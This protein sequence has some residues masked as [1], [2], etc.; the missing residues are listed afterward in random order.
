M[1]DAPKPLVIGP[2]SI[3]PT[4]GL[5]TEANAGHP[6][7]APGYAI[8]EHIVVGVSVLVIT[9]T[10]PG[11]QITSGYLSQE[12]PVRSWVHAQLRTTVY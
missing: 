1:Q 7:G 3:E 9:G 10:E 4:R 12:T 11:P 2:V 6:P 8:E 5:G